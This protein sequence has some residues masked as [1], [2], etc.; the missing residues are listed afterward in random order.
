MGFMILFAILI[1]TSFS[2]EG[3]RLP[4]PGLG[5]CSLS[6]Y[7][8]SYGSGIESAFTGEN[9]RHQFHDETCYQLGFQYAQDAISKDG[10]EWCEKEFKKAYP[11][12]LRAQVQEVG[13]LCY[14][15]GFS[16]GRAALGIG[17][18][19]GKVDRVGA[20]CVSAYKKGVKDGKEGRISS[21]SSSKPL[22]MYC[23]QLGHYEFQLFP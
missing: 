22:E 9:L 3:L 19:E 4:I 10:R 14:T 1:Q 18:R 17:A 7:S 12:G 23:Y 8:D 2:H 20:P 6:T 13:S 21:V 16:A 5:M 11:T 15:L